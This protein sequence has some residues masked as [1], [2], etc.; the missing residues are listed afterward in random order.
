MKRVANTFIAAVGGAFEGLFTFGLALILAASAAVALTSLANRGTID[1]D[2][3]IPRSVVSPTQAT[4]LQIDGTPEQQ[5][6]VKQ[7]FDDIVWPVDPSGFTIVVTS[8]SNLPPNAAGTY[9]FPDNVISLS[10]DVVNDPSRQVLVQVL[11]H[12]VGHMFDCVYLDDAARSQFL[13]LRG[14]PVGTDWRSEDSDWAQRPSEDFAEVYAAF[15]A[16]S[17]GMP[18]ATNIGRTNNPERIEALITQYQPTAER[19]KSVRADTALS[20]ARETMGA[21][22]N[23]PMVLQWLLAL[24]ILW[25]VFGAARAIGDLPYR[26]RLRRARVS[27]QVPTHHTDP[28]GS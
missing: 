20:F 27:A 7:A 18:I 3:F 13:A 19:S 22:G 1:L 23:D 28:H 21:M 26:T 5:A 9:L 16:P 24:A 25:A 8:P 4:G 6:A 17:S 2:A 14:F 11:A 15:A 12:E 10:S